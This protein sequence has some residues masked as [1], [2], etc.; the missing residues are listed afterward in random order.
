MMTDIPVAAASSAAPPSHRV[1]SAANDVRQDETHHHHPTACGDAMIVHMRLCECERCAQAVRVYRQCLATCEDWLIIQQTAEEERSTLRATI[2]AATCRLERMRARGDADAP[3]IAAAVDELAAAE[4]CIAAAVARGHCSFSPLSE[5]KFGRRQSP[6]GSGPQG[7]RSRG[8]SPVSPPLP[9]TSVGNGYR[10]IAQAYTRCAS[11]TRVLGGDLESTLNMFKETIPGLHPRVC[12]DAIRQHRCMNSFTERLAN[13]SEWPIDC[14]AWG[15]SDKSH[16]D[17][18]GR[19]TQSTASLSPKA[20]RVA[21]ADALTTAIDADRHPA[22]YQRWTSAYQSAFADV[23]G[24]RVAECAEDI[25]ADVRAANIDQTNG[26]AVREPN[27]RSYHLGHPEEEEEIG[28]AHACGST[29]A[30]SGTGSASHEVIDAEEEPAPHAAAPSASYEVIADEAT[31]G[32]VVPSASFE[33]IADEATLGVVAPS[34]SYEVIA[35][36]ATPHVAASQSLVAEVRP[37][38]TDTGV[39]DNDDADAYLRAFQH[40]ALG[41]ALLKHVGSLHVISTILDYVDEDKRTTA[42][43]VDDHITEPD[44]VALMRSELGRALL[45]HIRSK[46]LLIGIISCS[47]RVRRCLVESEE[48]EWTR[49]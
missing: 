41:R 19:T 37:I 21:R 28:C 11:P 10:R 8:L 3:A 38:T 2:D 34:A 14:V 18:D 33:V 43:L 9:S 44:V 45:K 17:P 47:E 20:E 39:I 16:S 31:S 12:T 26:V 7:C 1:P 35:D 42:A 13:G 27:A 24:K 6:G 30:R 36:E 49:V 40:S 25:N 46:R 23:C 29:L 48:D 5:T 32:V 22:G 4:K 15:R